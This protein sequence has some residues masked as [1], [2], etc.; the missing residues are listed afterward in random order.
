[1]LANHFNNP[2]FLKV[3]NIEVENPNILYKFVVNSNGSDHTGTVVDT[4][5][6]A[7]VFPY[8][9]QSYCN[10]HKKVLIINV[11]DIQQTQ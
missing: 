3:I 2:K 10:S 4:D 6:D 11:I 5:P 8:K 9:L 1:M 7:T